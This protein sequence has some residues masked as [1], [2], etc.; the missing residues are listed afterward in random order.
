MIKIATQR[1]TNIQ[2]LKDNKIPYI[3]VKYYSTKR[4]RDKLENKEG[5]DE[6]LTY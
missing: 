6:E 5:K 2:D 1:K 4:G 3:H